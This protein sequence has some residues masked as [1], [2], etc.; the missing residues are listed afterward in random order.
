MAI[1]TTTPPR[2]SRSRAISGS[3][4]RGCTARRAESASSVAAAASPRAPLGLDDLRDLLRSVNET[5]VQLEATHAALRE[6]V[7]RLQAELAEANTQL[8]RSRSLAALGEMAAGIAHEIRNPLGSIQLYVQMLGEDLMDRPPQAAMC[9][10][11]SQAVGGLDAIV[12]DVLTFARDAA[13]RPGPATASDLFDRALVNCQALI[14]HGRVEVRRDD[15]A[16]PPVPLRADAHR[17]IQALTNVIR[18]AVDAMVECEDR[19]RVLTVSAARQPR[20]AP[21][22]RRALRVILAVEDTGPGIPPEVIERMFNPFFTTR[23]TGTGLGLAIVHRIV[24]AHGGHVSVSNTTRG[25]ARVEL[26]LPPRPG[27]ASDEPDSRC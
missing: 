26:C 17:L 6:Q 11:I 23:R 16:Q 10:K 2:R 12:Q 25:G 27:R 4:S 1:T 9:A 5:T 24:D 14:H 3:A 20:C 7:A 15:A 22:G 13:V 21:G 19:P 18:N 8:R